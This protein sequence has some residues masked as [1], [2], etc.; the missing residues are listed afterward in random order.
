MNDT[1]GDI[2]TEEFSDV[3]QDK[4][5]LIIKKE[6]EK[7]EQIQE[8][9]NKLE[10][11]ER[12]DLDELKRKWKRLDSKAHQERKTLTAFRQFLVASI[13]AEY[14]QELNEAESELEGKRDELR[15]KLLADLEDKKKALEIEKLQADVSGNVIDN[16]EGKN[17]F[18]RKLRVRPS[19]FREDNIP[20]QNQNS[21]AQHGLAWLKKQPNY[22]PNLDR[23]PIARRLGPG[24]VHLLSEQEIQDDL[25]I[26]KT[27]SRKR[28]STQ[29]S[30][31]NKK[32]IA[33]RDGKMK[34]G[35]K[36]FYKHEP[37]I[38]Q[39][40]DGQKEN[41]KIIAI[42]DTAVEVRKEDSTRFRISIGKISRGKIKF[43]KLAPPQ[44]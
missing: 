41:A 8:Y 40:R 3:S 39:R 37:V 31:P 2:S 4:E 6:N 29:T 30:L 25:R 28:S 26:I 24:L 36:W 27:N 10:K 19:K 13:Q 38:I 16:F 43:V 35:Q 18:T 7:I 21:P 14:N 17:H 5:E 32:E 23:R 22:D 34:I 15:S 44:N 1:A 12:D 11:L 42:T 33:I 9:K 20:E